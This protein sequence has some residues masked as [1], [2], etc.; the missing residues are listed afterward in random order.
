H[1][2]KNWPPIAFSPKTRMIYLPANNNMCSSNMGVEVQYTPGKAFV[3]VGGSQPFTVP[4]AD[5]FGAGL[6]R[7]YRAARVDT[8]LSKAPDLGFDAG[9]RRRARFQR[10]NQRPQAPRLRCL[11]G[12]AAMGIS[13]KLRNPRPSDIIRCRW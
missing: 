10:W 5:H 4:G 13:D 7:R 6:E 2:G 3:G 9:Y 1:G 8:Q 12:E 11:D